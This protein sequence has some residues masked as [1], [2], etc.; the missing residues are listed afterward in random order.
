MMATDA[1]SEAEAKTAQA[2]DEYRAASAAVALSDR[3]GTNDPALQGQLDA[4]EAK[5]H[6]AKRYEKDVRS[7]V[8]Q[9]MFPDDATKELDVLEHEIAALRQSLSDTKSALRAKVHARNLLLARADVRQAVDA[10]DPATRQAYAEVIGA[11]AIES[12]ERVNA[13]S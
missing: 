4:A 10:M 1:L 9:P 3:E 8:P 7:S 13:P 12:E 5:L 2:K 6:Q 11:Q